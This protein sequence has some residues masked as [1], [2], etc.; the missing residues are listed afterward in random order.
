[1][2]GEAFRR[3]YL[4]GE[5]VRWPT[6]DSCVGKATHKAAEYDLG[7]KM[8]MGGLL[9]ESDYK[10]L[11]ASI[12]DATWN[13]DPP[14]VPD[15]R[16][17]KGAAK[18]QTVGLASLHHESLAPT[19]DPTEVE[20]VRSVPLAGFPMDLYGIIDVVESNSGVRDLKTRRA[21]P[22]GEA[23]GLQGEFYVFM[24]RLRSGKTP[25]HF[26][27]DTIVKKKKPEIVTEYVT[28]TGDHSAMVARLERAA[29]VIERGAFMPAEPGHWKCSE[30]YCEYWHS[31]PFGRRRRLSIGA[32]T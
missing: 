31:C 21:R 10:D 27:V 1:M 7:W 3:R 5:R 2:C 18:D 30:R 24:E 9:P 6:V 15:R 16:T 22:T 14:D 17:V 23:A 20:A 19:L 11:A 32:S 28:P 8:K 4:D 29:L 26:A 25:T 12:F 13:E